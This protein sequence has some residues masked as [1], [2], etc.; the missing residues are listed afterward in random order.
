VSALELVPAFVEA[1]KS[2]AASTS[3]LP[4]TPSK[5]SPTSSIPTRKATMQI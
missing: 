5:E 3:G 2:F 1:A 4:E